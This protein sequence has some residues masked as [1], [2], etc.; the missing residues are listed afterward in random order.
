MRIPSPIAIHSALLA[1]LLLTACGRDRQAASVVAIGDPA[2]PFVTGAR[3]PPPARLLRGATVE[4]LVDL[5]EQGQIVP[6]LADRWIITDDGL[7]YIFRLRDGNWA[8]GR[9]LTA[10]TVR[11][12][13]RETLAGLRG[14][15]LALDLGGI[16][17]IRAMTTRVIE[18]RLAAPMP[19][20]LQLLAQPELGLAR[21]GRGTGPM[22]LQR[23]GKAIL[24]TPVPPDSLGLP[25]V[26]GW[27][28]QVRPLR[29]AALPAEAALARFNSGGADILL[30]GTIDDFPLARSVGLIRATIQVDPVAGLF[31]L[32]VVTDD[33][34][35]AAP[36]NREALAMAIDRDSL[37]EPFGVS[38]WA[39]TT[40]MVE[41]GMADDTG[42][43]GERWPGLPI[44]ARRA[45]AAQR[46][47]RWRHAQPG[48]PAVRLR[49]GL[50]P[51]KGGD[52]LFGRL[53]AD[54]GAI[55]IE[56][57]RVGPHA[58]A[59]LRLV[60][61][62]AR[63]PRVLWFLH[64]LSCAARRG[65]CSAEADGLAAE[66]QHTADPQQRANLLAEA[67]AELT[68]ANV[69]IPFGAPIRWSLVRGDARGF[70]VNRWNV[71]PLMPMALRPK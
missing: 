4:G 23:Q 20:L 9:P 58:E 70:A 55:G 69:F 24:L 21:K 46:V 41:P 64:Q 13:L 32:A 29:F 50:P 33:G 11:G 39:A 35:L 25:A 1:A 52:A 18:I 44:A 17:E 37:M 63:Y 62:V 12:A 34:F 60:E 2:S 54:F 61:A 31:G 43:I 22:R 71:H 57:A 16:D 47:A 68:R 45:Q 10:E 67:E 40:R 14:T 27:K 65:L 38:G 42:M 8:D 30:G 28:D 19:E 66:A 53:Q 7:S 48:A 59:E 6:A 36:A 3:L 56:V 51:G 5:D 49:I 15:P 26:E